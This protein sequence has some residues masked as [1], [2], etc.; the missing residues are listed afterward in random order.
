MSIKPADTDWMLVF[1]Y[2][3]L[4]L[5]SIAQKR[6]EIRNRSIPIYSID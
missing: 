4:V 1:I 2:G 5:P 3:G 6:H